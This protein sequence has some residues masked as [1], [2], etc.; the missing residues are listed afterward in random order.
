MGSIDT[1]KSKTKGTRYK[2]K[3]QIRKKSKGIDY[4]DSAT[5]STKALARQWIE[6]QEK[7]LDENPHLLLSN[8]INP[9]AMTLHSAILKYLDE[10]TDFGRSKAS[11]LRLIAKLP[12]AQKQITQLKRMDYAEHANAR[13]NGDYLADFGLDKVSPATINMDLQYIQTILNHADLIWGLDVNTDELTKAIKGLRKARIIGDPVDRFRLPTSEE[14]QK[15]T[16]ASLIHF[17]MTSY[18]DCPLHLI[19]WFKIY[20]SRRL[21]ELV[22][23]KIDNFDREHSRWLLE[24]VKNPNGTK[25]NDKYFI[26]DER[27]LPIIELLLD[28]AIRK[29]MLKRGGDP[30]L[31]IPFSEESIDRTWQKMKR[32][33]GIENLHFHDLRHEA[34]TR[35]AE[36]GMTIPQIQ[37]YTLHDDWNSLKIYVNMN[38][39]RKKVLDFDEAINVAKQT[40]LCEVI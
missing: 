33:T 2:A 39:I 35:L 31:L 15:I 36:K 14:L 4:F 40:A 20:T 8:A 13:K 5:F 26:V 6:Q 12:I 18:S 34:A 7:L 9:G 27:A 24:A 29:R 16:T 10:V 1:L 32:K 21:G 25:G 3:I 28:P 30:R 19:L 38:T 23:L 22:R 11:T 17:S 37:Q